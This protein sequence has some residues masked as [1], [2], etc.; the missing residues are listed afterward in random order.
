[1][2]SKIGRTNFVE[3]FALTSRIGLS[4]V[5][6]RLKSSTSSTAEPHSGSRPEPV[7]PKQFVSF[8]TFRLLTA[9]IESKISLI[10]TSVNLDAVSLPINV[11]KSSCSICSTSIPMIAGT[12]ASDALLVRGLMI[13]T[14]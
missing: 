3:I 6:T 5:P 12:D 7:M 4:N 8:S 13:A 14:A 1:M 10:S 2:L 9:L 11:A